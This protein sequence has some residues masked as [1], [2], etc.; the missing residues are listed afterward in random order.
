MANEFIYDLSKGENVT[1]NIR[2]E[3]D[4][5]GEPLNDS[6]GSFSGC[7]GLV[8]RNLSDM[9]LDEVTYPSPAIDIEQG[10]L[11]TDIFTRF[12]SYYTPPD[13]RE[14]KAV[15]LE[16]CFL[17]LSEGVWFLCCTTFLAILLLL[18]VHITLRQ[19]L[20]RQVFKK[21]SNSFARGNRYILYQVLTHMTKCGHLWNCSGALKKIIFICLSV[22]SFVVLFYFA[23]MMSTEQVVVKLPDMFKSYQDL[24]RRK[25]GL[26]FLLFSDIYVQFKFAAP[27]TVESRLWKLTSSKY[28]EQEI[29]FETDPEFVGKALARTLSRETVGVT[30]SSWAPFMLHHMCL[31]VVD[32]NIIDQLAGQLKFTP[33]K[34][35]SIYPYLGYDQNAASL[36]RGFILSDTPT[37]P[38]KRIKHFLRRLLETGYLLK[39]SARVGQVDVFATIYPSR[40]KKS[41]VDP[42]FQQCDNNRVIMPEVH[43]E[44]TGLQNM[45]NLLCIIFGIYAALLPVLLAEKIVARLTLKTRKRVA[46]REMSASH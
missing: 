6:D 2:S 34:A 45:K 40:V 38:V 11:S 10:H 19:K 3:K 26:S 32:Q 42:D 28:E 22:F 8:Q 27:K 39:R 31:I 23:A 43:L 16:S 12:F 1:I 24:L 25:V 13:Q 20:L 5:I 30:D 37:A 9:L 36:M 35:K 14:S 7:I 15:Q 21:K 4:G 41:T 46:P 17:S 29:L 33:F 18:A 44:S